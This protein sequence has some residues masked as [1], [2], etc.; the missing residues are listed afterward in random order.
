MGLYYTPY[1]VDSLGLLAYA[2]VPLALIINQSIGVVSNALTV[3]FTRFYSVSFQK[4][5][6]IGAS[7]NLSTSFIATFI[8]ALAVIPIMILFILNIEKVFTIP[9]EYIS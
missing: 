7:K 2:I 3:A 6:F 5:D 8:I 9:E 1:L 4:K